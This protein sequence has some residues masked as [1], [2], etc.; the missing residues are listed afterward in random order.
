MAQFAVLIYATDSAHAPDATAA[1]TASCDEHAGELTAEG[2]MLLAYALTPRG[3]ATSLRAGST[4]PGPFVDAE[5]VV[6]GFY[7]LEAPDLDAAVALARTNPV[8]REG[9]GVE[10]RPV[11]SGGLVEGPPTVAG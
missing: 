7:V 6:A 3:S 4:T 2:S 5:H 1:D 11:H 10:V 8:L 9:G